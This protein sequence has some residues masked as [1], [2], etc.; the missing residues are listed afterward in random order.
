MDIDAAKTPPMPIDEIDEKN[1]GMDIPEGGNGSEKRGWGEGDGGDFCEDGFF[2]CYVLRSVNPLYTGYTYVGF[3]VNPIRRLRQHNGSI[4]SGARQTRMRR[5]WEMVL[6]VYGFQKQTQALRFE[7]AW[8]HPRK[9][10]AVREA[11]KAVR[12]RAG[13]KA[14]IQILFTMLTVSAWRHLPI[15]VQFLSRDYYV[16]YTNC[17][18]PAVPEQMSVF[19]GPAEDLPCY[20][21]RRRSSTERRLIVE[22]D[23]QKKSEVVEGGD[24]GSKNDAEVEEKA[25]TMDGGARLS[26]KLRKSSCKR[27]RRDSEGHQLVPGEEGTSCSKGRRSAVRKKSKIGQDVP[28]ERAGKDRNSKILRTY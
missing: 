5:P 9:S 16:L 14:R 7:W 11:A 28:G 10:V 22:T 4:K 17:L 20:A 18:C 1:P 2:A 13:L 23:G 26:T 24:N 12:A 21:G 25:H 6:V 3:T 19:V 8:K 27:S 15:R